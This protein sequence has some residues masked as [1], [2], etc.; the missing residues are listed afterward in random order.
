MNLVA[1]YKVLT[2]WLMLIEWCMHMTHR[3]PFLTLAE[4]QN[5]QIKQINK[6]ISLIY[7]NIISTLKSWETIFCKLLFFLYQR[8]LMLIC[9]SILSIVSNK[10]LTNLS[11][12]F[13]SPLFNKCVQ[14]C[15]IVLKPVVPDA[16]N[17]TLS[18]TTT[19]QVFV[20]RFVTNVAN[21]S[22]R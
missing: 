18:N 10:N 15:T 2:P 3:D 20:P 12:A 13:F 22:I 9:A 11:I 21:S 14:K 4:V 5:I 1:W 7:Y 16:T 8:S 17:E 6:R 19:S